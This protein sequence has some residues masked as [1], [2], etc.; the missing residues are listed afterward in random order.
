LLECTQ[1]DVR[2]IDWSNI[3]ETETEKLLGF[4]PNYSAY[5][6]KYALI[7]EELPKYLQEWLEENNTKINFITDLGV[8]T[9]DSTLLALRRFF[10]NEVTFNKSKIAQ[11]SR[12][13]D[14]K[15]L[16]NTFEWLKENEIKLSSTE[17]FEVFEEI[18]RVIN[19][20][21]SKNREL[22]IQS[23]Y[24]FELLENEVSE[25]EETY[26][27]DWKEALEDKYSIFLF[28]GALPKIVKLDEIDD[29]VFYRYNQGDVVIDNQNNIY[30]N[31][32]ADIKKALSSLISDDN[33]DFSTEDL[34]L[35][36]QTKETVQS[37]N[38]EVIELKNEVERLRKVIESLTR[39]SGRDNNNVTTKID[40]YFTEIKEKSEAYLFNHLKKSY[41]FQI[42][43]WL[44]Y[45]EH[46]EQFEESWKNH[47][48][49]IL[50]KNGT[51]LHYID[52]KGTPQQKKTF[53]LTSNEWEFFLD[54]VQNK[55][56][57]QIYRIFNTEGNPNFVHIDDLWQ[58]IETGRVVPYLLAEETIKGGRVFLTL[59]Q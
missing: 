54:C 59:K 3:N 16:F 22:V 10:N 14:E 40:V 28:E 38:D 24:D 27:K 36:Y 13:L 42:V 56:S 49:E 5:P 51:V 52:C 9:N 43:K 7:S 45:N 23:E 55:K 58:W 37:E 33:N 1:T 30:I 44:N 4:N 25:W 20:N 31:R 21:R 50:N 6:S 48:F 15:M 41:P 8:F 17:E 29:Y 19:S 46:T 47:D 57:Y 39:V 2:N 11:D 26:Y 34:L 12:L 35:L 53:Y 18:V 32:N